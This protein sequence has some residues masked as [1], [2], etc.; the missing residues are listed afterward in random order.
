M[1]II[2]LI[3]KHYIFQCYDSYT[4][5]VHTIITFLYLRHYVCQLPY[6]EQYILQPSSIFYTRFLQLLWARTCLNLRLRLLK[7]ILPTGVSVV[8]VS[9][10]IE[11]EFKTILFMKHRLC[12][13]DR[14]Q[15]MFVYH[16]N[17]RLHGQSSCACHKTYYS[18]SDCSVST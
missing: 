2:D 3:N 16:C 9:K 1:K 4:V 15:N 12:T 18:V 17:F 7:R 5:L 13:S 11:F 10:H 8:T 14:H 6:E